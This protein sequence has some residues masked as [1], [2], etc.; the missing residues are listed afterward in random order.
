[1]SSLTPCNFCSHQSLMRRAKAEGL[2][3]TTRGEGGWIAAYA[4]PPEITI[5]R[6][7]LASDSTEYEK[8]RRASYMALTDHCVC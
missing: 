3:V 4:H 7:A 5:S 8:Y 6:A 1:M 2:I